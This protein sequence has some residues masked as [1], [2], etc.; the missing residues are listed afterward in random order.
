[1]RRSVS[2]EEPVLPTFLERRSMRG[3]SVGEARID[4]A[5]RWEGSTRPTGTVRGNWL[6]PGRG[7]S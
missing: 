5:L 7:G 1:V 2:F 6:E 4:V 3:L